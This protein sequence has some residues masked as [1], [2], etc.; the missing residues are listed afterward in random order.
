MGW[1]CIEV[2][3]ALGH[4]VIGAGFGLLAGGAAAGSVACSLV[5]RFFDRGSAQADGTGLLPESTSLG[6]GRRLR[7]PATM[8]LRLGS[9][10][11]AFQEVD[12]L[13]GSVFMESK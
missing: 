1:G 3:A 5:C 4:D 8:R 12:D 13:D 11:I 2:V 10:P 9:S 7:G 6:A